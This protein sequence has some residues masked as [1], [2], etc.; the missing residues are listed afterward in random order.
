M[1]NE[2]LGK[3]VKS[4]RKHPVVRVVVWVL[5]WIGVAFL[6][7]SQQVASRPFVDGQSVSWS[8]ALQ[9]PLLMAAWWSLMAIL[10]PRV[11]RRY[12]LERGSWLFSFCVHLIFASV[13]SCLFVAL[14]GT[15]MYVIASNSTYTDYSREWELTWWNIFFAFA[16]ITFHSNMLIYFAIL[17]V[18]QTMDFNRKLRERERQT[19]QLQ[20]DL[21]SA[22]FDQLRAQLQPHFLFNTLSAITTFV[23][24]DPQTAKKM[25][26]SLS[27]LLRVVV[28]QPSARTRRLEEELDFLRKY[29]EIQSARFGSRFVFEE[30]VDSCAMDVQIPFLLFQPL[31]ENAI[32][33]GVCETTEVCHV[34]LSVKVNE[35]RVQI[36]VSDT[37]PGSDPET[38]V[39]G[40]GLRN[41]KSRIAHLYGDEHEFRV[42]SG[43]S[44]FI[45]KIALPARYGREIE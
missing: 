20:V 8:K 9:L 36:A 11:I 24:R 14:C 39:E 7:A 15:V 30:E 44:G 13:L 22:R 28:D 38:L 42:E 18:G 17:A 6:F 5:I 4:K 32:K 12:P 40:V 26:V 45:V 43:D 1:S 23:D 25:I 37:G 10:V 33:H 3:D 29:V 19:S 21:I 34:K 27:D 31:V 35:N 16:R 2:D 41:T